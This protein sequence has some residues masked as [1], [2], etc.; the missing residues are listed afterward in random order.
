[1]LT[2]SATQALSILRDASLFQWYV[3]PL[4]A[5]LGLGVLEREVTDPDSPLRLSP[6][7]PRLLLG[8]RYENRSCK[9]NYGRDYLFGGDLRVGGV[10]RTRL[11]LA[12]K[13]GIY[14]TPTE[15]RDISLLGRD[16]SRPIASKV[17]HITIYRSGV[18][19]SPYQYLS[20][21]SFDARGDHNIF[22]TRPK[23]SEK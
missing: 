15:G 13:G 4:F 12:D 5:Y 18:R 16:I 7:L 6:L 1:M 11:D 3:I 2:E 19:C 22:G 21:N 17:L 8:A 23:R 14:A 20:A 9:S 10:R